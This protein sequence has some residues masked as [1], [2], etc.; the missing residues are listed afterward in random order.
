VF[1][2]YF[3]HNFIAQLRSAPRRKK[4]AIGMLTLGT[5]IPPFFKTTLCSSHATPPIQVYADTTLVFIIF[6]HFSRHITLRQTRYTP[7]HLTTLPP[8]AHT[9]PQGQYYLAVKHM[10]RL[11]LRRFHG[12]VTYTRYSDTHV[13]RTDVP[14][15]LYIN[16]N[17]YVKI[18]T[19]QKGERVT[20]CM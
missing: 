18:T 17:K 6:I 4:I 9:F 3:F 2:F 19:K 13:F 1:F 14:I 7:T 16:Q 10:Q 11:S 20:E 15:L 12:N 5:D 8:S